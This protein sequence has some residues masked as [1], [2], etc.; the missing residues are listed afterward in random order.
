MKAATVAPQ[1]KAPTFDGDGDHG[2]GDDANVDYE[3]VS[4]FCSRTMIF[5]AQ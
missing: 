1:Q 3:R 4:W 5:N 2:I